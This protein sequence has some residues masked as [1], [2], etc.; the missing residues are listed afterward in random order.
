[1]SQWPEMRARSF[2]GTIPLTDAAENLLSRN[3]QE[4]LRRIATV[5][6]CRRGTVIFSEGEEARFIYFMDEGIVRIGRCAESGHRQILAFR[7]QGDLLGIPDGGRYVNSAETVS[8][9]RVYRFS[10]LEMQQLMLSE[11]KLQFNLLMKVTYEFRQA[12]SR[13]MSLGQQNTCQRLASFLVDLI[14]VAEFFD[15]KRRYLK[16]PVNR[17]D[18]ADY[19]GTVP[20]S[21]ARAFTKLE[22]LGLVRRITARTIEVL[23]IDGLQ[24]LQRGPRRCHSVGTIT[25]AVQGTELKRAER[26]QLAG[27]RTVQRR[28]RDKPNHTGNPVPV[29]A[30]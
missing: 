29:L 10:W 27:S 12:Q 11:P 3:E 28:R 16:L 7:V 18:L 21:A 4:Q 17:F 24:S 26:S 1:M 30:R 22:S 5:V 6:S 25:T 15:A 23:D 2:G 13:I 20:E 14:R 19:L 8:A 9:V